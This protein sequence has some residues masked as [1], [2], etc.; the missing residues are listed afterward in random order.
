M[1]LIH[2]AYLTSGFHVLI[3]NMP[4]LASQASQSAQLSQS[5]LYNNNNIIIV[6]EEAIYDT[7]EYYLEKL[8]FIKL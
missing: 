7:I 8:L 5:S 6:D 1:K 4:E 3:S 2:N